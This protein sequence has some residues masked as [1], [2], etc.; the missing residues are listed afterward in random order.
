MEK[1][2]AFDESTEKLHFLDY[3]QVISKR[4]E[5]IIATSLIIIFVAMMLS[6]ILPNKYTGNSTI[7][8]ESSIK[9]IP[10]QPTMN[11]GRPDILDPQDFMTHYALMTSPRVLDRVIAGKVTRTIYKCSKHP[12]VMLEVPTTNGLCPEK[13]CGLSL[14][15]EEEP[16]YKDWES[17]DVKWA[18]RDKLDRN[19]TPQETQ[20]MLLKNFSIETRRGTKLIDVHFTS[21]DRHEAADVANMLCEVYLQYT[22]E[23]N[24]RNLVDAING[25][26]TQLWQLLR[27]TKDEKGKIIEPGLLDLEAELSQIKRDYRLIVDQR[28]PR[29]PTLMGWF[30]VGPLL[31]QEKQVQVQIATERITLTAWQSLKGD[32]SVVFSTKSQ[33]VLNIKQAI[34]SQKA[35]LSKAEQD[36]GPEHPIVKQ[37]GE[38]IKELEKNLNA[39]IDGIITN[40]AQLVESLEKQREE[41]NRIINEAKDDNYKNEEGFA[42]YKLK[43]D[44]VERK[45]AVYST[46]SQTNTLQTIKQALPTV[47][48]QMTEWAQSPI[49]PSAPDRRMNMIIGIIAGLT[50]GTGLAYFIEYLD[51]SIKTIDDIERTLGLQILGVIPQKVRILTEESQNSPAYEAYRILWT[52]I[53][54]ARQDNRIQSIMVTSGGV[55]EGKTTTVVNLAIAIANSGLNV[56]LIDSDFR[57]PRIHRL[58]DVSN[59]VGLT[60]ILMRNADPDGV[61]VRSSVPNLW[62]V[63]SGKLPANA[64]GLLTSKRLKECVDHFANKYDIVLYDSPP[65]LGLSDTAVLASIVDRVLMCVEYRKYPR[66]ISLRAR[67]I[68]ENVGGKMLGAVVNNINVLKEDPTY[69]SQVYHYF[70][71]PVEETKET[72]D[73]EPKEKKKVADSHRKHYEDRDGWK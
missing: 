65:V 33:A 70:Q 32:R 44:E 36:Y 66:T 22:D 50:I 18:K 54:F 72:F 39:E 12:N 53:E 67:K 28:D 68:L 15:M 7:K 55:A 49:Y 42:K 14:S 1:S 58:L 41:I 59:E 3:W 46:I 4:K 43:L 24:K 19:Y 38:L 40:Q 45:S 37:I 23:E 5:V 17:L 11:T 57:R 10:L 20:I 6:L 73:E 62:I 34:L 63:P 60:D 25:L 52:N 29:N 16:K 71:T 13:D 56:L 48:L 26:R 35:E 8:V 64:V 31:Q 61:V 27:G 2:N 9:D 51:T 30:D 69:Y 47:T 21:A